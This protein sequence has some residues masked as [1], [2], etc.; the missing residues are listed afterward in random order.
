MPMEA[1]HRLTH[2]QPYGRQ[3]VC[4]FGCKWNTLQNFTQSEQK[5]YDGV[6]K[7]EMDTDGWRHGY[8]VMER[9]VLHTNLLNAQGYCVLDMVISLP[10]CTAATTSR[11]ILKLYIETMAH[12]LRA[13]GSEAK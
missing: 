9:C 5:R 3:V 13:S 10:S 2:G 4:F 8:G 6:Y 7:G 12:V 1:G 11:L